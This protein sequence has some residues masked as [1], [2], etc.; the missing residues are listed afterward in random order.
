MYDL[1]EGIDF[2]QTTVSSLYF[3]KDT[4]MSHIRDVRSREVVINF[5]LDA[6]GFT[7]VIPSVWPLKLFTNLGGL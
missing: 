5:P 6:K 1:L 2:F 4:I 7:L 3:S